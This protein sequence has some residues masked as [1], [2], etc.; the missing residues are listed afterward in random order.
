ME[1]IGVFL[2]GSEEA[3]ASLDF[4]IKEAA[5]RCARLRLISAWEVPQSM[6]GAGVGGKELYDQFRE[7]AE[8]LVEEGVARAAE[9]APSV[10]CERR[11]AKGQPNAVFL[12]ESQGCTL[13]VAARRRQGTVR[14]LVLGSISRHI[15][16]HAECPVV[17]IP[18]LTPRKTPGEANG[19]KGS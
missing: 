16:N 8:A 18:V 9:L 17:V 6:L 11:V 2:N 19:A 1:T 14:E 15:L 13:V 12:E 5:L 7:S 3:A 10:E 4:G